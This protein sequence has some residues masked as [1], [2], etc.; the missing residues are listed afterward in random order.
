MNSSSK[1]ED[2]KR[3]I[4]PIKPCTQQS[5]KS[6]FSFLKS[7]CNHIYPSHLC[8]NIFILIFGITS[9]VISLKY[10][11]SPS[12]FQTI[13][14]SLSLAG[15]TSGSFIF[16]K[17]CCEI[18]TK[19]LDDQEV[20]KVLS[21]NKNCPSL[22]RVKKHLR[23]LRTAEKLIN[24]IGLIGL[25]IT[26]KYLSDIDKFFVAQ[27]F[28]S[29]AGQIPV[30]LGLNS[31]L[32]LGRQTLPFFNNNQ[33][34][35]DKSNPNTVI[36]D[37]ATG[38]FCILTGLFLIVL[39]DILFTSTI[40]WLCLIFG[41]A[42]LTIGIIKTIRTSITIFI[43]QQQTQR[44]S[45]TRLKK[46][47]KSK[48]NFKE[49]LKKQKAKLIGG[50]I[51]LILGTAL[52][53]LSCLESLK[54]HQKIIIQTFGSK[55]I[56]ASLPLALSILGAKLFQLYPKKKQHS[57]NPKNQEEILNQEVLSFEQCQNISQKCSTFLVKKHKSLSPKQKII[58]GFFA[59]LSGILFIIFS[60]TA[61]L[62]PVNK[63]FVLIGHTSITTGYYLVLTR[64]KKIPS[65]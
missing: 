49:M 25:G 39:A 61:F 24:S 50:G 40:E 26:I 38:L 18:L 60:L 30:I 45:N 9:A 48:F 46:M 23:Y 16:I 11:H 62:A 32:I 28:L 56:M 63:A 1:A 17:N 35:S 13:L 6:F 10:L 29:H 51:F 64:F 21:H 43:N 58:L 53:F 19:Y 33:N 55:T 14:M 4:C 65:T 34:S 8:V 31:F 7:K 36:S 2:A 41:P 5:K 37:I 22:K 59:I 57:S 20:E 54:H 44:L 27:T 3:G 12:F 47:H 42:F 15:I 52:T